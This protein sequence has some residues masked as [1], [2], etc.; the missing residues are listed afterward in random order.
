MIGTSMMGD[1]GG[2]FGGLDLDKSPGD[3]GVTT[4]ERGDVIYDPYAAQSIDKTK[5]TFTPVTAGMS[6]WDV[7]AGLTVNPQSRRQFLA[8]ATGSITEAPVTAGVSGD[9]LGEFLLPQPAAERPS[10]RERREQ[11]K[12]LRR[13]PQRGRPFMNWLIGGDWR[14]QADRR[15]FLKN[16]AM[17]I[18][19][20]MNPALRMPI[21]GYRMYEGMKDLNP[22]DRREF[23]AKNL[24]SGV[25]GRRFGPGAS[26]LGGIMAL[27]Q[28]APAR[29]IFANMLVGNAPRSYRDIVGG[30]ASM[31]NDTKGKRTWGQTARNIG[32]GRTYGYLTQQFGNQLYKGGVDPQYIPMMASRMAKRA[33]QGM[34]NLIP[35]GP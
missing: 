23:F 11:R 1:L 13:G 30:I 4:N 7:P 24:M 25:L 27:R 33:T 15:G 35:G 3:V 28:G 29:S 17:N 20:I 32:M 6:R 34:G 31:M 22:A 12:A 16:A 14:N 2:G 8:N 10:F 21:M 18:A 19:G 26:A 9:N 5:R